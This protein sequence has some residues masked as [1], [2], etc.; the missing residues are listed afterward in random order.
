M[1]HL[2][3]ACTAA[4][5]ALPAAAVR[6]PPMWATLMMALRLAMVQARVSL[7]RSAAAAALD[8]ALPLLGRLLDQLLGPATT[9]PPQCAQQRTAASFSLAP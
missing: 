8:L 2:S 7:G 4:D 6:R 1:L 5:A 3:L 9:A